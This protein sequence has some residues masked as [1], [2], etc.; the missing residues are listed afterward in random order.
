MNPDETLLYLQ[1]QL[2]ELRIQTSIDKFF[3]LKMTCPDCNRKIGMINL[4]RCFQCGLWICGKCASKHFGVNKA[5]LPRA[6]KVT[7]D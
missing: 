7:N 1:K 6:I 4:Y 3:K 2:K 5:E